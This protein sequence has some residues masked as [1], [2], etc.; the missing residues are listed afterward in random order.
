MAEKIKVLITVKTYP[1]PS[2]KYLELVC[3]AGMLEDGSFIRLYPIDYRYMPYAKWYQ[4]YQWIEVEV[5]K[6]NQDTRK[7]SF[8][9]VRESILR[10]GDP[11]DTGPDHTWAKRKAIVLKNPPSSIEMLRDLREKDNTS[12]GIVKPR[13]VL[14]FIY[15]PDTE[16]WKPE[17]QAAMA[18]QFLFG[19]DRKPLKKVPYKFSYKFTC[20]DSRCKGH[21]MM[22]EDWEVGQLFWN[23]MTR[24]G[25]K[26][27]AAASVRRKFLDEICAPRREVYFFVGTV[28]RF[29]SWIILGVFWP[30]KLEEPP[31][32]GRA[33]TA[34]PPA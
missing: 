13:E 1:L 15:E 20:D 33:S 10:I 23:E 19:P 8:R 16:E 12:L 30:P 25:K 7:E 6:H 34:K 18:Q 27:R 29:G 32:F 24:L 9:P 14:D 17:W 2:A 3:T 31:L 28:V 26:E 4:K 5:E 11:I 21:A 22:I